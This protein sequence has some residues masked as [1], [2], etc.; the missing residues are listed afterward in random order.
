[1]EFTLHISVGFI[2]ELTLLKVWSKADQEARLQA[3]LSLVGRYHH[4]VDRF[5]FRYGSEID[6]A[7]LIDLSQL[8]TTRIGPPFNVVLVVNYGQGSLSKNRN[9]QALV[10]ILPYISFE[11]ETHS[12]LEDPLRYFPAFL[13]EVAHVLC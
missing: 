13:E 2:Q 12:H 3:M 8:I 5:S 7:F 11:M 1:M 9:L 6:P 4:A 10:D